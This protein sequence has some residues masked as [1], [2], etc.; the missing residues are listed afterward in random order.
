MRQ[1]LDRFIQRALDFLKRRRAFQKHGIDVLA[2][3]F[4]KQQAIAQGADAI[5]VSGRVT[6]EPPT[7]AD[8]REARLA[9][10]D[11][12][13]LVGSGLAPQNAAALLQVADGALVGTS[14]KHSTA[15]HERVMPERVRRLLEVV[16]A[17]RAA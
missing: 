8:L 4:V 1:R 7:L 17:L 2:A 3:H 12:P 11:F 9:V 15:V 5:V 13:V 10:G 16:H 14:L 6:G